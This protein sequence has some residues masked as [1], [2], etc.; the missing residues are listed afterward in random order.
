MSKRYSLFLFLLAVALIVAALP[1]EALAQA[2][3]LKSAKQAA[4]FDDVQYNLKVGAAG[5]PRLIALFA[6]G[7]GAFFAISGLLKMKDWM[8]DPTRTTVR[9]F[10]LRFIVAALLVYMPHVYTVTTGA[11]FGT[12]AKGG[13]AMTAN[14]RIRSGNFRSFEK[15]K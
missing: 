3:P 4:D 1:Q 11:L 14:D 9:E 6:Y 12:N 15:T 7:A 2:Q 10:L 5:L 8:D 13:M